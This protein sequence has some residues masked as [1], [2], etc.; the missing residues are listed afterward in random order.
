MPLFPNFPKQLYKKAIFHSFKVNFETTNFVICRKNFII[1]ADRTFMTAQQ[2]PLVKA[3][4]NLNEENQS[5]VYDSRRSRRKIIHAMSLAKWLFY[6]QRAS[7]RKH[8]ANELQLN[9]AH[10]VHTPLGSLR[11][12]L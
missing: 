3:K 2:R 5:N 8:S 6:R 7:F 11:C 1:R 10:K 9:V 12:S 4:L